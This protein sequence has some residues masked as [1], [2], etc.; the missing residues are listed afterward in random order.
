MFFETT[1]KPIKT[2]SVLYGPLFNPNPDVSCRLRLYYY[3]NSF[4]SS[5]GSLSVSFRTAVGG[6]HKQMWLREGPVGD[7]WERAEIYIPVIESPFQIIVEANVESN[8]KDEGIIAVDDISF[9]SFCTPFLGSLPTIVT[10]TTSKPCGA[11]GYQCADGTCISKDQV[12][13]FNP[14]CPSNEDET[15]C[16]TCNF[17]SDQCGW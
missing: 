12:C 7:R 4:G 15:D 5:V 2:T 11:N 6:G 1:N 9:S 8:S 3:I 16:G 10:P 14:D 17:E 13:D